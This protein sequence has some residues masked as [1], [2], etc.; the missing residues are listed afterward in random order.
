MA[1]DCEKMDKKKKKNKTADLLA[2][3][4]PLWISLARYT[5]EKLPSPITFPNI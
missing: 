1:D 5:V 4:L 3:S 2:H